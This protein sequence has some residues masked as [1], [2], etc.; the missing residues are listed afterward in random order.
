MLPFIE[1]SSQKKYLQTTLPSIAEIYPEMHV[2]EGAKK[3]SS[4]ARSSVR[5]AYLTAKPTPPP[6]H[7][8]HPHPNLSAATGSSKLSPEKE[9]RKGGAEG[10]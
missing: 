7:H 10:H 3:Q 2:E 5:Y 4:G 8:H 9:G 1:L 6:P